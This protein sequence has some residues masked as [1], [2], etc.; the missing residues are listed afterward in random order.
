MKTRASH[1]QAALTR[2]LVKGVPAREEFRAAA[3]R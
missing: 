1:K 3:L 2:L